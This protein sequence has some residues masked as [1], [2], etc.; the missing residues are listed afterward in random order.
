[1]TV[2]TVTVTGSHPGEALLCPVV[3]KTT[4]VERFPAEVQRPWGC[5]RP[6]VP[7]P[8]RPSPS[9]AWR[10]DPLPLRE[11]GEGPASDSSSCSFCFPRPPCGLSRVP[12]GA[13]GRPG[14]HGE[15]RGTAPGPAVRS[16]SRRRPRGPF[17]SQRQHGVSSTLLFWAVGAAVL[18]SGAE[19]GVGRRE[20]A[21]PQAAFHPRVATVMTSFL[22]IASVAGPGWPQTHQ[23]AGPS[24]GCGGRKW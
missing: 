7:P 23:E 9:P 19:S 5:L 17:S 24:V 11:G 16:R 2:A 4:P 1:M 15:A 6:C 3:L 22:S 20:T 10:C 18:W 13:G 14:G 8:A 12:S 21:R